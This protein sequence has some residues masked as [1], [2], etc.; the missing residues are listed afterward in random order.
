MS[1]FGDADVCTRSELL[2]RPTTHLATAIRTRAP[3]IP[4]HVPPLKHAR[5]TRDQGRKSESDTVSS[6]SM[7]DKE[8]LTSIL[9]TD[10][11]SQEAGLRVPILRTQSELE[12]PPVVCRHVDPD[13]DQLP[14]RV[15]PDR[16]SSAV[17]TSDLPGS[18]HLEVP[19]VS[20]LSTLATI[21]GPLPAKAPAVCLVI[22]VVGWGSEPES[23]GRR[24][25]WRI[26]KPCVTSNS[27]DKTKQDKGQQQRHCPFKKWWKSEPGFQT[28]TTLLLLKC[29]GIPASFTIVTSSQQ[30]TYFKVKQ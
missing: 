28:S 1:S 10:G 20:A 15:A 26:Y 6:G 27:F 25:C 23:P 18:R 7:S 12:V 22:I 11:V 17:L 30:V 4:S 19:G 16:D 2:L 9:E 21:L 13:L 3:V 29:S 24:P 8:L 14:G 5:V